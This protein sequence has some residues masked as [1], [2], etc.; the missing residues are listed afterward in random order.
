MKRRAIAPG[1][2]G[3]YAQ[4]VE[5]EGPSRWLFVS[6][7]TPESD[8]APLPEAF[9]DQCRLAW[10]NVDSRL[11][12]AGMTLDNLVNVT[13]FLGERQYAQANRVIRGEVLGDRAPALTVVAA[14][15]LD[16]D[17]KVEINAV[18]VA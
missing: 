7:Q 5:I 9:E 17:W 15:L 10:R 4:A 18:A 13:V 3:G 2:S 12:A 6:G 14:Q 1:P 11:Q 8:E 16:T